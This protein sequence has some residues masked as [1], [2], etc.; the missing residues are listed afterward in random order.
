MQIGPLLELRSSSPFIDKAS[1][2]VLILLPGF[3][4]AVSRT[5]LRAEGRT[6][7]SSSLRG[8]DYAMA[9]TTGCASAP[10]LHWAKGALGWNSKTG[11]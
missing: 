7:G 11:R 3:L 6:Q 10:E 8:H 1:L 4:R 9:R 5:L 2:G